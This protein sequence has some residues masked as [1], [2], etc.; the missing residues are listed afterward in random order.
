M[1]AQSPSSTGS[2]DVDNLFNGTDTAQTA[3]PPGASV[4]GSA[5]DMFGDSKLHFFGSLNLYGELG[6]GWS[7]LPTLE[8]SGSSLGYDLG[9]S[10]STSLGFEVRPSANLRIRGTLSYS[11]PGTTAEAESIP[12]LSEMFFDYSV[13]DA[14]FFRA[15]VFDYTWGNSQFYQFGNLP[16][17]GLPNWSG[18]SNLPFWERTNLMTTVTTKNY[19]VSLK[20]NLPV[21]QGGLTLISRFDLENYFANPGAPSPQNTGYG[22]EYDLVTGPVDWTLAG[23]YQV[24]LTPRSLL[25]MKTSLLGFDLS[26]EATMAFPVT[27]PAGGGWYVGGPLQRIYPT[28]VIGISREWSDPDIRLYAEYAYNGE[29]DPGV[30]WLPDETGPGGQNSAIGV[31]LANVAKSALS[32]NLLWQQNWSDGSGLI[33]PFVEVS[34]ISMITIQIGLP[35]LYGPDN[36]EVMENRLIPGGQQIELLILLKISGSFRQ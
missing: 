8:Q 35:I 3:T 14:V 16:S 2:S 6:A 33:A 31:R 19:P 26:A 20:M 28:A 13:L 12:L 9:G 22:A 23:F 1:C 30:S 7:G 29:R 4:P 18:V 36:S 10:M 15:G 24:E 17:R 5:E 11:F 25:S 21:G 27:P 32:L 34:P